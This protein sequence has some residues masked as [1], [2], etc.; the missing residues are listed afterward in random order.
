MSIWNYAEEDSWDLTHNI[1]G[2]KINVGSAPAIY[3]K[4]I[5]S[6]VRFDEHITRN[7]DDTDFVYRLSQHKEFTFGVGDT[8]IRQL[9]FPELRMYLRK[10]MWYGLCDGE[11]VHK[12]PQR[13]YPVLFHLLVRY[14]F[15]YSGRALRRGKLRA[16]PFFVLQGAVRFVGLVSYFAESVLFARV[17]GIS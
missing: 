9:H 11:F 10:F 16:I 6:K 8:Q 15:V 17:R 13:T 5:F 4:A 12:Y 3:K 14:P 7:S 2:P 1:P